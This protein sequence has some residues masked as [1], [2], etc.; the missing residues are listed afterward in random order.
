MQV[1]YAGCLLAALLLSA[2][3]GSSDKSK[4]TAASGPQRLDVTARDFALKING[5]AALRPGPVTITAR[6]SGEQA[7]GMVLVKLNDGVDTSQL[8]DALTNKPDRIANLLTYVGGTTTLPKGASWTATTSFDEGNY[9]ML[10]VGASKAGRLNFTRP[11][12]VQAFTVSG[13]KV[14]TGAQPATAE[15]SLYD[16]GINI[17]KV[18]ASNGRIKVENTGSDDHQLVFL[19]VKSTREAR[20]IVRA[21]RTGKST[22]TSYRPIEVLAPTSSA[23][24]STVSYRLPKGAYI[25]YCSYRT[26]RSQGRVHAGLGMLA[27]FAVQ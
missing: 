11:G 6:N 8:V 27:A 22:R 13:D 15:V 1:R 3:G 16:Y 25:A 21:F 4:T 5:S 18:I 20:Q 23:T 26:A 17:P 12:E 24:S 19:P 9:A 2:C 7:H 14:T 10:D